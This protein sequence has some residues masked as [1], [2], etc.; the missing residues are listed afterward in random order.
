MVPTLCLDELLTSG[1]AP[2]GSPVWL[3]LVSEPRR[4]TDEPLCWM[5]S[6]LLDFVV[7]LTCDDE[8]DQRIVTIDTQNLLKD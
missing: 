7:I 5:L 3:E 4:R 2:A 6:I 1:R 8:N